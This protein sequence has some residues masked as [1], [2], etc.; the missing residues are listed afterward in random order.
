MDDAAFGVTHVVRGRDLATSTATQL[1]LQRLLELSEPIYRH[2][3][4]LLEEHEGGKLAKLHGAVGAEELKGVYSPT[5]LVG[6]LAHA[7]GLRE[8]VSSC[9]P[10]ELV[11]DFDWRRVTTE[12]RVMRWTGEQLFVR[13]G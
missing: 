11:A 3:A 2:H 8:D 12:D 6:V 4:L 1:A 7:A 5:E 13:N 10:R 9:E